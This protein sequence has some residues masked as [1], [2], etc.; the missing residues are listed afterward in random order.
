MQPLRQCRVIDASSY[1]TGPLAA[2]MLADL[3]ADVIKVEPPDGDPYRRIGTRRAGM[4]VGALNV[5]RGKRS[6]ALDLKTDEGRRH[7]A[8]LLAG[9][10]V[11]VENW[12]PGVADRLGLDDDLLAGRFP[13]LL[14]VAIT[15]YGPDGPMADHGAF[16]NLMQARTGL[17]RLRFSEG[18]PAPLP[19]YLADKITSVM[20]VQAVLGAL[21]ERE[22]TGLGG[23]L[24]VPMLDATA[25]FNFTDVME[26]RTVVDGDDR[27]SGGSWLPAA[28]TVSTIVETTD[29]WIAVS[30][31]SRGHVI[32][33]CEAAGHPE[34]IEELSEYKRFVDLGPELM[35]RVE[36]VTRTGASEEWLARFTAAGV[37]VA[38]VLDADGHLD[39]PQV[40]HNEIYAELVHPVAGRVRYPR[41][42]ARLRRSDGTVESGPKSMRPMPAVGEHNDELLGQALT[43]ATPAER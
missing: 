9:A 20:A 6:V 36:T 40:R 31:S 33:V 28:A 22:R 25:Y 3:G 42:P 13:R 2:V 32:A 1:V 29:G 38:P 19:T 15:G 11:L 37:P 30:P 23:R 27:E 16:D 7:F 14:H 10:D 18:R 43:P 35:Q 8:D 39:D 41:F 17:A 21:L 5:N 24:D 34:W 26:A 4:A 12:R